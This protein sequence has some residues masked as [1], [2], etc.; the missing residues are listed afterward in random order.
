MRSGQREIAVVVERRG[1]PCCRRVA[2][3][4][5]LPCIGVKFGLWRGMAR[6]ALATHIGAEQ[7]VGETLLCRFDQFW[8]AVIGMAID[9][10][11]LGQRLVEG[12]RAALLHNRN[13]LGRA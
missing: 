7:R 1:F 3:C 13:A 5:F 12:D 9:A 6:A 10:R 2:G 11:R 8:V 4:A